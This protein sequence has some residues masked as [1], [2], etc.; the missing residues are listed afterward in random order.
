MDEKRILIVDDDESLVDSFQMILR[1]DGHLVETATTGQQAIDKAKETKIHL[2]IIDI[3][4]PDLRGDEVAR[5]LKRQD[6]KI[7]IVLITG[8]PYFQDCIDALDIG[9]K[10]ILLKPINAYELIQVAREALLETIMI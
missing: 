2:A 7:G 1:G 3:I 5:Q 10:E 4:L 9:V 8:Y 6:E